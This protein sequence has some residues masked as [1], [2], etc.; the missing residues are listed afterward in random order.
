M[1]RNPLVRARTVALALVAGL[2][3]CA[4]PPAA[5]PA[6][7]ADPPPAGF[8]PV[9]AKLLPTVVSI[10]VRTA[11]QKNSDAG[12][13]PA[14]YASQASQGSGFIIDPSGYIVTNRHVIE[15]AYDITVVLEDQ[16]FL[17]ARLVGKMKRM[18]LALLKVDTTAPLPTVSFGDSSKMRPGDPVIAIGNPLGLGGTVT[19]GVVSA[20]NRNIQET[21]FDDYIQID[22]PI[23]HGNSGGPLFNA[24]GEL[25]GVNT[26]FFSPSGGSAGLSFA[27]PSNDVAWIF[28]Q[29][30]KYHEVRAGWVDVQVQDV[31]N[32]I[33]AAFGHNDPGGAIVV[34]VKP[35]S[36]AAKAG[37]KQ[38][39]IILSF[40]GKAVTDVRALARAVGMSR[41]GQPAPMQVWRGSQTVMLSVPVVEYTGPG[42]INGIME[43]PAD[44]NVAQGM[45]APHLGLTL[46]PLTPELRRKWGIAANQTGLLIQS[47]APFSIAEAHELRPGEVIAS[48]MDTPITSVEQALKV[49][50]GMM[51]Q[52][53]PYIAL[54]VANDNGTR[55]VPLPISEGV[56]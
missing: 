47:V 19:T 8:A 48:V 43:P 52:K 6:F 21:P 10:Y 28:D 53:E 12:K 7:A 51:A 16:R 37:V 50:G 54:L 30:R 5:Q 9:V 44:A 38:G 15:G 11:V 55:W 4:A 56:P 24:S 2:S 23:N 32:E 49:V 1:S 20:L 18:D 46:V 40:D 17:K 13:G 25:V 39:D 31:S 34:S 45:K 26:A 42:G 29:M 36:I 35:D 22:A 14:Q 3:F 41:I 27:I 33:G